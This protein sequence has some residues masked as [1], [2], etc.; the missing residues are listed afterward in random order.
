MSKSKKLWL[1]IFTFL[2]TLFIIGYLVS[3][4]AFFMGISQSAFEQSEPESLFASFGVLFLFLFLAIITGLAMMIYYII[5]AAKNKAF[6][7]NNRLIWIL[8]LIFASGVGAIV[9][10]FVN[11]YPLPTE[12][13]TDVSTNFDG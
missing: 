5:H 11:I 9:Y 1:G 2:P 3:F 12:E 4:F 10:F 13:S 7:E 6:T 8:V